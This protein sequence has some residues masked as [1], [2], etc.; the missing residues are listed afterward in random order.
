MDYSKWLDDKGYPGTRQSDGSYDG[1]D[2]A[3]VIG[4]IMALSQPLTEQLLSSR[5]VIPFDVIAGAPL[6]HPDKTKW[7]GQPDRFSRD[8]LIA[9]LCGLMYNR[10]ANPGAIYASHRQ[11]RFLTAWN[12]KKNGAMAV[13][14]KTP[15]FTGPEVWGLWLRIYKPWWARAVLWFC[16]LESL[17]GTIHWR[18]FRRDRVCRNHMLVCLA[19][20]DHL[21]TW[22]SK[23]SYKINKW[24]DLIA[25]WTAHCEAVG[26]FPTGDLFRH[27]Y[28]KKSRYRW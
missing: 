7:Y 24:D 27:R 6:R 13:P 16:D 26:E 9:V 22:V 15:D 10:Q 3:A 11:R 1:G 28:E 8:Q 17:G 19:S 12:T 21:P 4:T 23:L 25:R 5:V 2:T 20:Q 18:F 14:D